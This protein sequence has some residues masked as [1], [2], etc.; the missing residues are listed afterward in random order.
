LIILVIIELVGEY[1]IILVHIKTWFH[2]FV[3]LIIFTLKQRKLVVKMIS[4]QIFVISIYSFDYK[5][6]SS[7]SSMKL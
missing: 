5:E 3:L 1:L 6:W 4:W 7:N 2:C